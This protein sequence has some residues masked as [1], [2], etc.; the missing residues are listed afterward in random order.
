MLLW[1]R[2]A[3]NVW[4]MD[5]AKGHD[6]REVIIVDLPPVTCC[7]ETGAPT[8][9]ATVSFAGPSAP[10]TMLEPGP[11]GTNAMKS[12]ALTAAWWHTRAIAPTSTTPP[13][14]LG[15]LNAIKPYLHGRV[16]MNGVRARSLMTQSELVQEASSLTRLSR[17]TSQAVG[18]M[19]K[20]ISG[21]LPV[22]F[23]PCIRVAGC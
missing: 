1:I 23:L 9:T 12:L 14:E 19:D 21:G 10:R 18:F 2:N 5:S 3:V 17:D 15:R 20:R 4:D 8:F 13:S 6:S 16:A 11:A 22:P 7:P